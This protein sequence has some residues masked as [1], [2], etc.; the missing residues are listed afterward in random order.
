MTPSTSP[1]PD[2]A[3]LTGVLRA[4]M[5][6]V[7]QQFTHIVALRAWGDR[8][9][10]ERIT[11][12]DN[13]DFATAIRVIAFLVSRG[14]VPSP[15]PDNVVP[16]ATGAE[17]LL[18]E[19]VV[20]ERLAAAIAAADCRAEEARGLIAEAAAPRASYARWLRRQ[21]RAADCRPRPPGGNGAVDALFSALM[22]WIEQTTIH[23]FLHWRR[24][25]RAMADAAWASSGAAMMRATALTRALAALRTTPAPGRIEAPRVSGDPSE[26]QELDRA[27][28]LKC[29]E[30]AQAA[31]GTADDTLVRTECGLTAEMA[32]LISAWRPAAPHPALAT[33]PPGLTTLEDPLMAHV[34][35]RQGRRGEA[36]SAERPE[37]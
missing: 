33:N 25:N 8:A 37:E 10:A 35:S 7:N 21:T 18:A 22:T 29:A 2:I 30:L 31:A 4:Q 19:L 23:A 17:S 3:P 12:V 6:A 14:A 32:S 9:L 13:A 26:A 36:A 27:I 11:Q 24:P 28:A 16:G 34:W 20:E 5:T 1:D 15:G